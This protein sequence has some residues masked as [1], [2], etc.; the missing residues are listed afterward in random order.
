MKLESQV[1]NLELSKKLKELGVEQESLCWWQATYSHPMGYTCEDCEENTNPD[2]KGVP[3]V[4]P[5]PCS[6]HVA[7]Y[8]EVQEEGFDISAFTVAEL[9]EM[10]LKGCWDSGSCNGG[11]EVGFSNGN[12]LPSENLKEGVDRYFIIDESEANARALMLIYLLENN[13]LD[14]KE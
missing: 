14:N 7:V 3:R 8:D 4:T 10:L 6:W 9:G 12:P 2:E 11:H 5:H 13:L 1:T